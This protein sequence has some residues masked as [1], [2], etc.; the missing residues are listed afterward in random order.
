MFSDVN[1]PTSFPDAYMYDIRDDLVGLAVSGNT[2]FALTTGYPWA[3]T[4][5]APES[6][7]PNVLSSPQG[8]VS[9]RSICVMDGS[10]F[11]ASQDGICLLSPSSATV[12]VITEKHFGKDEWAALNPS[13]CIMESYDGCLHCWFTLAG[14]ERRGYI[15]DLRETAAA[16]TTHDEQAKAVCAD[17]VSDSLYFVRAL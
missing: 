15:I 16:V 12:S 9:A 8:C 2:V 4:G 14:S 11:Y 13:S 6:M 1:R 5:T 7:S 3:I 10:V 17:V